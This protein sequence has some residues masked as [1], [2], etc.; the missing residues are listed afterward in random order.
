MA[1]NLGMPTD[2][3][4]SIDPREAM[5]IDYGVPNCPRPV[6]ARVMMVRVV[7]RRGMVV[8]VL[9]LIAA[10]LVGASAPRSSPAAAASTVVP[11]DYRYAMGFSATQGANQWSYLQWDG[12]SYTPMVWEPERNRWRGNCEFCVISRTGVHPDTNDAVIA[13]TAPRGGAVTVRGTMDHQTYIDPD[14][15]NVDGTRTFVR[16]RSGSTTSKVW[17]SADYQQVRPGFMA[18]HVF[19]TTVAAGDVLLFH[20]NRGGTALHDTLSWDPRISYDYEPTFT[21]DQAELVMDRADFDRIGERIALDASLSV[22]PNGNQFDFYH[23]SDFG[24]QVQKF[25]GD[26]A[27]PAQVKVYADTTVNRFRNPHGL[28]GQWWISSMYRTAEGHLLAFCHI[29]NADPQSSG[30]WAGGLAYSTDNGEHFTLLG[31]TLAAHDRAPDGSTGNMGGMPYALKDGY[32]HVY[33]TEFGMPVVA[34]AP[35]DEVID[36]ARRGTVSPWAKYYNNT[37]TEPGMHG[38]ATEVVSASPT[39]AYGTHGGAAYSTYLGKYLLAGGSGGQGKG[40][41]LAFGDDPARFDTPSWLLSSN[42]NDKPTLQPYQ[43]IVGVD[44]STNGVVGREFYVYYGYFFRWPHGGV[45]IPKHLRWLYRQKVTLNAAGFDRNT[46]SLSTDASNKQDENGLRYQEYDGT[47]YTDMRWM[48]TDRR[49]HGSAQFSVLD[50]IGWHPD[51]NR[52]SVRIWKAPRAGTVRIGAGLDGIRTGGSPGA[53]GIRVKVAKN[54]TPVWPASGYA[55]VPPATTL[56][57]Q[58]VNVTVAAG[59]RIAF[60]VHQNGTSAYDATTWLPTLT[61]TGGSRISWSGNGDFG[62]AQGANQW[63]YQEFDGTHYTPMTWDATHQ[64]WQGTAPYLQIGTVSQHADGNRE[65]VRAWVAPRAGT[66]RIT[67]VLGD[68][69]TDNHQHQKGTTAYDTLNWVPQIAYRP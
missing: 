69:Y 1:P 31:K 6:G 66:V 43:T 67:S 52:D 14:I 13:W 18:Q 17:P 56:P 25:R 40:M 7:P 62:S 55:L 27:R 33:Y 16:K 39:N 21:L 38:R 59:D 8:L 42:A 58:P 15:T 51:G 50:S 29:E 3:V 37:W 45:D 46:V 48:D 32:F 61:Y 57:F 11:D 35:V 9:V 63:S 24:R 28:D 64:R 30:W 10:G 47:T 12:A 5:V 22:I 19:T 2:S 54:G 34:R 20:A 26:L 4:S 23:S 41:F 65:S 53:D 60:H 36:A 44:G 68:L 49:W